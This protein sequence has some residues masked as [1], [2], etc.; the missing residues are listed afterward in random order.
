MDEIQ[1]I[2]PYACAGNSTSQIR[3]P[4]DNGTEHHEYFGGIPHFIA[5]VS[6]APPFGLF[7]LVVLGFLIYCSRRKIKRFFP[8]SMKELRYEALILVGRRT[9]YNPQ[10]EKE[11]QESANW[12]NVNE[13]LDRQNDIL[14]ETKAL[15]KEA[16]RLWLTTFAPLRENGEVS[17]EV[18]NNRETLQRSTEA[19]FSEAR[20]LRF[21]VRTRV[22]RT[23]MGWH[24]ATHPEE[25]VEIVQALQRIRTLRQEVNALRHEVR[26]LQREVEAQGGINRVHSIARRSSFHVLFHSREIQEELLSRERGEVRSYR[27]ITRGQRYEDMIHNQSQYHGIDRYS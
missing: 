4:W 25:A 20:N 19:L 24:A 2:L 1:G 15:K 16:L 5:I 22:S 26:A 18:H 6:Y 8:S 7:I 12:R 3:P 13:C 9:R 23:I 10:R 17:N 11:A 21:M 14:D 27:F